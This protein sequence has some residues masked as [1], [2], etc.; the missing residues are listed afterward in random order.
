M[1]IFYSIFLNRNPGKFHLLNLMLQEYALLTIET[2][3]DKAVHIG[4]QRNVQQHMKKTGIKSLPSI[5]YTFFRV[6]SYIPP[7]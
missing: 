1:P 3:H 6:E 5:Y 2:Q 7:K 4:Y